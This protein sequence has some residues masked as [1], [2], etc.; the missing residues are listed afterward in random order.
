MFG[1]PAWLVIAVVVGLVVAWGLV[2][3]TVASA[4]GRKGSGP[5]PSVVADDEREP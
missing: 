2:W 5:R 1:V 4:F 3:Y